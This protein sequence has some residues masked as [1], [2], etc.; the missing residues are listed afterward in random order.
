[1]QTRKGSVHNLDNS[2]EIVISKFLCFDSTFHSYIW[3]L[4]CLQLNT[5]CIAN[6]MAAVR[7]WVYWV[8]LLQIFLPFLSIL[9][10]MPK[11]HSKLFFLRT[12]LKDYSIPYLDP[13]TMFSVKQVHHEKIVAQELSDQSLKVSHPTIHDPCCLHYITWN[14][15]YFK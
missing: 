13:E 1:M 12:W 10:V 14:Q 6:C 4:S 8:F 15:F 11:I 5:L 2:Q 9:Q 3:G 7:S